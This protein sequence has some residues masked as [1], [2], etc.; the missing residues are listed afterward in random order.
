LA[1]LAGLG[2]AYGDT[3]PLTVSAAFCISLLG[4]SA[5]VRMWAWLA[6]LHGEHRAVALTEGEVLVSF[7]GITAPLLLGGFA[8]TALAWHFAFVVGGAACVLAALAIVFRRGSNRAASPRAD[9]VPAPAQV[10]VRPTL[11]VVFA[12]VALEFAL[13]FW[14]ASYLTDGVG[15]ARS[16][17]VIMVS[18]LYGANLAGRVITSRLARRL[19]TE[20][21][22]AGA[23]VVILGGVPILLSAG[24]VVV[25]AVGI[26]VV[27]AG[28]GATFPLSSSLHVGTR[29]HEADAAIGQVL[30]VASPGQLLGPLMV[31]AIGQVAGLRV[32]LLVLPA[33]VLLAGLGLSRHVAA[34][35][36]TPD[37]PGRGSPIQ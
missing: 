37:Q 31:G 27:G 15:L 1:G 36:A 34:A 12:I 13:S 24:G 23:L 2:V 22:L 10:R 20:W 19:P 4:T 14:L 17:G 11:I 25:A 26:A 28:I 9:A 21:V 8:A 29:P 32:G 33:C 18:G 30:A 7:G 5:L 35:G 6:D 3:W 16:T